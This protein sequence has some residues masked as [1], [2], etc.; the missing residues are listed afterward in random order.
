[1]LIWMDITAYQLKP[2]SNIIRVEDGKT[3]SRDRK[4]GGGD[5][6]KCKGTGSKM[7]GGMVKRSG[8][9]SEGEKRG[10]I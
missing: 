5:E 10:R 2:L 1:M 6:Q 4:G 3:L 8:E 9:Q 7:K